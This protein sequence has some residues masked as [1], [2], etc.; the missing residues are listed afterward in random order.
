VV[1]RLSATNSTG[2]NG[3]NQLLQ[4]RRKL[5][6]SALERLSTEPELAPDLSVVAELRNA[7]AMLRSCFDGDRLG[8]SQ[9]SVLGE[10]VGEAGFSARIGEMGIG[11]TGVVSGTGGSVGETGT[12]PPWA[13]GSIQWRHQHSRLFYGISLKPLSSLP[14]REPPERPA[15][16]ASWRRGAGRSAVAASG[17]CWAVGRRSWRSTAEEPSKVVPEGKPRGTL[18][19]WSRT[20][21][22]RPRA[23]PTRYAGYSERIGLRWLS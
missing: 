12:S 15:F 11:D 23:L 21:Y 17:F 2:G 1:C 16:P 14:W 13:T 22:W 4:K 5:S 7:R 6:R 9:P 10:D 20:T 3:G 8:D 18:E 19:F